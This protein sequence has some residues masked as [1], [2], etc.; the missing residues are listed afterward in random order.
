M[1]VHVCCI[2]IYICAGGGGGDVGS[3]IE[4]SEISA[5]SS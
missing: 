3:E 5:E 2:C 4:L 1:C